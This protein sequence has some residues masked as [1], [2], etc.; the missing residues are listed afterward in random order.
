[1]ETS[2]ARGGGR[3]RGKGTVSLAGAILL[4][5]TL[6]L[7]LTL[8]GIV[9]ASA[10]SCVPGPDANLTGCDLYGADLTGAN[11]TGA[12]L[13]GANLTNATLTNA[14]LTDATGT[15]VDLQG[16]LIEGATLT[17]SS[18]HNALL[19]GT[20]LEDS[21]IDGASFTGSDF[22]GVVSGGD[23]GSGYALPT[24]WSLAS[25]GYLVG[26]GADLTGATLTGTDLTSA[27]LTGANLTDADINSATL[28]GATLTGVVSGGITGTPSL[29]AN[30]SVASG[31]LVGPG[32]F[33]YGAN[34]KDADLTGADAAGANLEGAV[35]TGADLTGADLAN[36]DA[37]D[38]TLTGADLSG[39]ILTGANL[40]GVTSGSITGTP[41]ALPTAVPTNW[42]FVD[43]YLVGPYA[44]L[45]GADLAGAYLA[46]SD[47][48]FANLT[49]AN[50]GGSDLSS[51]YIT[52]AK[53]QG[54]DLAGAI[55]TGVISFDIEGTPAELPTGW[56][57]VNG[58]LKFTSTPQS[59]A[60]S[61]K[62]KKPTKA[63]PKATAHK[64]AAPKVAAPRQA[65]S[66]PAV[67][68]PQH[69]IDVF[70]QDNCQPDAEWQQNATNEMQGIKSLGANSV[71][72]AFPFYM[73]GPTTNTVFTADL[74]SQAEPSPV[75]LRSPSPARLAILVQAAES[76]GLQV[77]VRPLMDQ[78]NLDAFGDWRGVVAPTSD[79]AWFA[80]YESM[81]K[82]YLEMAQANDVAL[83]TISSELSSLG[84]ASQWP[85]VVTFAS[86]L[87]SGQLVFDTSWNVDPALGDIH[88]G[89][90]VAQDAYPLLPSLTPTSTVAQILAAWNGYLKLK[91]L[92]VADDHV[93]FDEVGIEA[94]DGAY[95]TPNVP[96]S[97]GSTF[98]QNIQANWFTAACEFAQA[99]KLEGLYFWGPEL[100]YNYGNLMTQP[101]AAQPSE[102]QPATQK[103]I[104][105][106]FG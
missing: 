5:L 78:S 88:S 63:A 4:A 101:V 23:S 99:H 89:T 104:Q 72:I 27:N 20:S 97:G 100:S 92:P 75:P 58:T 102:L 47:L 17:G 38:V 67:T 50:L 34:F 87:Y 76:A 28:T 24:N 68:I 43:G 14:T 77:M 105:K 61:P 19:N 36:V 25:S 12:T 90:A 79:P 32:A 3:P 6:I 91:P 93:T 21:N 46:S 82:P 40:A 13:T 73:T 71:S 18:F 10:A 62:V 9:P 65:G 8:T 42:Q 94:I 49:N 96:P 2:G 86:K 56:S 81:L 41:A 44:N 30:W 98:N 60:G 53:L 33:L 69:G 35:L 45:T 64:A 52:F 26:P 15:G 70:A 83:F 84:T 106:C 11:L 66:P 57:I 80:S 95:A 7:T 39:T 103:A 31:Y 59:R 55:L 54:T 74:C 37:I 29:P 16:A 22:T 1:M 51:S 48:H 85:S